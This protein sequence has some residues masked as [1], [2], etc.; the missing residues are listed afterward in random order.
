MSRFDGEVGRWLLDCQDHGT[1]TLLQG[2][3][4]ILEESAEPAMVHGPAGAVPVRDLQVVVRVGVL[5]AALAL[6][7][8]GHS[9]GC[10]LYTSDAA[11]D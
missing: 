6:E 1:L 3:D 7:A 10:L 8:P 11:D 5:G 9:L 4:L 2:E